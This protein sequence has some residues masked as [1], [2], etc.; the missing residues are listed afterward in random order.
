MEVVGEGQLIIENVDGIDENVDNPALI[1]GIVDVA[2]FEAG[3]PI[4]D[5]GL[6]VA[7]A[8]NLRL[9]DTQFKVLLLF[10]QLFQSLFGGFGED[11]HL[12]S[13]EHVFDGLLTVC[14]LTVQSGERGIILFLQNWHCEIFS[15]NVGLP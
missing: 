10:L 5:L 8:L 7:W 4:H 14:Q 6:G 12:D 1:V 3:N 9:Q 15:V 2:I 11:T 13:V